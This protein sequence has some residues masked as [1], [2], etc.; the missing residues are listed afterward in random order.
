MVKG[1]I[2]QLHKSKVIYGERME[3]MVVR[4]GKETNQQEIVMGKPNTSRL[5]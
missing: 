1:E 5:R 4:Q 2:N 3:S